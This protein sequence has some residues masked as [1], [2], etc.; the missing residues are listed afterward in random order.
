MTPSTD[1][2]AAVQALVAALHRSDAEAYLSGLAPDVTFLLAREAAPLRGHADVRAAW[3]RWRAA[4]ERV[5]ACHAWDLEV[6]AVSPLLATAT[7]V[8]SLHLGG[9]AEPLHRRETL[10]LQRESDRGAWLVVHGHRSAHPYEWSG[11]L[12]AAAGGHEAF[13]AAG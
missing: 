13:A 2:R 5:E 4:G 9:R 7:H 8:L 1:A 10:V 12:P 11:A 6:R 3:E